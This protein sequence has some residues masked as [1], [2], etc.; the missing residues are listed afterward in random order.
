MLRPGSTSSGG[1]DVAQLTD[2]Q[3][4]RYAYAAG[5]RGGDLAIAVALTHPESGGDPQA[6]QKGQPAA[7]TGW[8]LW[9][10]TPG[11]TA[12]LDPQANANAAYAKYKA[13]GGFS[14]WTTF[15]NG[16][17]LHWL[18]Q[19]EAA[20]ARYQL[21]AVSNPLTS[22]GTGLLTGFHTDPWGIGQSIA[23]ATGYTGGTL[24][25]IGTQAQNAAM[26]GVGLLVL[27]AAAVIVGYLLLTRTDAGRGA[28]RVARDT[29]KAAKT[30]A[31]V[32][33]AVAP[34]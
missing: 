7:S 28:Q 17:Y 24:R 2:D 1:A 20:A 11:N 34:K 25:S 5:F 12:L 4:A 14:P 19:A 6:V 23:N 15:V 8:G 13:A 26:V 9:Q 18:P 22:K 16:T 3:V 33:V 21:G 29:Y 10:I 27:G 32:A 31:E 30:T